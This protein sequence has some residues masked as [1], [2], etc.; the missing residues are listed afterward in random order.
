MLI[1]C[2]WGHKNVVMS[3]YSIVVVVLMTIM[4]MG[5]QSTI[6]THPSNPP[7]MNNLES[8]NTVA[9]YPLPLGP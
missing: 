7:M 1:R 4:T 5:M 3:P 2:T 8:C 6:K 9:W